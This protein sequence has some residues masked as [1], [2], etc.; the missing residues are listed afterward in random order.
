[1]FI[2]NVHEHELIEII[3]YFEIFEVSIIVENGKS[4]F[5]RF[6]PKNV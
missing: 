1:M 3:S 6:N 2:L 5:K 4:F